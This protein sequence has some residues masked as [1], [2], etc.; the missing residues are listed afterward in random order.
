MKRC[1]TCK[2][3]KELSSFGRLKSSKD[4]YRHDCKSCRS[5]Y[6]KR[7]RLKIKEYKK[8]Y[9][10]NNKDIIIS[11]N[12][13]YYEENKEKIDSYV[14]DY[15]TLDE[16]KNRRK[17]NYK[18]W[19]SVNIDHIKEYKKSYYKNVTMT[20]PSKRL[21]CSIRSSVKRLIKNKSKSTENIVGCSYEHLIK[22]IE[23][24][25]ESW[26]SWDNYGK[27]NGD[28]NYGWD[29]DHIIPISYAKN[30]ED[31]IRLN[32]YTNLQPLCSKINRDIKNN[33][34]KY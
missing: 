19:K 6:I 18:K 17:I 10:T 16:N 15:W 5:E 30:D 7:N 29:I 23:S 2:I 14:K 21:K 9:Y 26:M 8:D 24:K 3:E 11:K 22:H 20:C 27:Y 33:R 1:C 25:F 13:K 28:F 31:L 12:K 4:G 34:I 32:H